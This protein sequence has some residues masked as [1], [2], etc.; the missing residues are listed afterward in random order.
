MYRSRC[1]SVL[2]VP[3]GCCGSTSQ[4]PG[5]CPL[6]PC[7][8]DRLRDKPHHVTARA[9]EDS[10]SC[11]GP[12]PCPVSG[13]PRSS[14]KRSCRAF[15][16]S[17]LGQQ[18]PGSLRRWWGAQ[19]PWGGA[20]VRRPQPN[21]V[22]GSFTPHARVHLGRVNVQNTTSR[23]APLAPYSQPRSLAPWLWWPRRPCG[24]VPIF[25]VLPP[26][27]SPRRLL[28]SKGPQERL[29]SGF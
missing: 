2:H 3:S 6:R 29:V 21:A 9:S 4:R 12:V 8:S 25:C 10:P 11:D 26:P 28:L 16:E 20:V 7:L 22:C 14:V 15:P 1:G 27:A 18:D 19:W 5:Q 13:G 24:L 23:H 17:V